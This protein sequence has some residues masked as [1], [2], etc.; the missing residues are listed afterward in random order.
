MQIYVMEYIRY[1]DGSYFQ[2]GRIRIGD[3]IGEVSENARE[4]MASYLRDRVVRRNRVEATRH[5]VVDEDG[6]RSERRRK[7]FLQAKLINC[8]PTL[9]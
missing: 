4:A 5:R 2:V 6:K 8:L 1:T 9:A 7:K 3:A